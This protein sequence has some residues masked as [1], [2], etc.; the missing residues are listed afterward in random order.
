VY[1]K[2]ADVTLEDA[3]LAPKPSS[4]TRPIFAFCDYSSLESKYFSGN[5]TFVYNYNDTISRWEPGATSPGAEYDNLDRIANVSLGVV[6][7][8]V[9]ASLTK[10][11]LEKSNYTIYGSTTPVHV[12]V[13]MRWAW[14]ILPGLLV[15]IGNIFLMSTVVAN[16]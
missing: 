1:R 16:S 10:L 7:S 6:M 9:A 15:L 3:S 2:P 12:Y 11:T 5:T 4:S 8:N 14:L 13:N